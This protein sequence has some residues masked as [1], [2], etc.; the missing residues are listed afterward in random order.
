MEYVSRL[1][2]PKQR[3]TA[4]KR[5]RLSEEDTG[6]RYKPGAQATTGR[7]AFLA[8]GYPL[9]PATCRMVG[10]IRHGLSH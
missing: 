6:P 10:A 3:A 8:Q 1:S 4:S 2:K 7:S 5:P 9:I